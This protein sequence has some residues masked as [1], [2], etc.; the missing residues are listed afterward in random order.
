MRYDSLDVDQEEVKYGI[1][2]VKL[3]TY[4]HKMVNS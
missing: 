2:I 3:L 1:D 4:Q